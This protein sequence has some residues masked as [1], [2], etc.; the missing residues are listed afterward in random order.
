MSLATCAHCHT[1]NVSLLY[2]CEHC[3]EHRDAQVSVDALPALIQACRVAISV[4][5]DS[6]REIDQAAITELRA[7]LMQTEGRS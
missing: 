3:G 1:N 5:R 7:A 2:V 6:K 4:L